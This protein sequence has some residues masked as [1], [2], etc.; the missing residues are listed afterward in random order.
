MECLFGSDE[1]KFTI[2]TPIETEAKIQVFVMLVRML[3]LKDFNGGEEQEEL[4][5]RGPAWRLTSNAEGESS[6][7]FYIKSKQYG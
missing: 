3:S 6:S 1:H 5:L 4:R 2:N 7:N